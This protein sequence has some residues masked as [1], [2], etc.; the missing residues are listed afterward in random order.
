MCGI[1]GVMQHPEATQLTRRMLA[2]M[3]HRGPDG[4]GIVDF[5]NGSL[6]MCRLRIRGP[7]SFPLPIR[8]E[9]TSTWVSYSGEIYGTVGSKESAPNGGPAEVRFMF[10]SALN[11]SQADGMFA[12]ASVTDR[13]GSVQSVRLSRDAFGIKP[14]YYRRISNGY[15]F[16]SEIAPLA[17]IP[18]ESLDLRAGAVAEF[19]AFGRVLADQTLYRQIESVPPG[20]TVQLDEQGATTTLTTPVADVPATASDLRPALRDSVQKCLVSDRQVGLALSGG[21]DSSIIAYELN[22][23]NVEDITTVSVCIPGVTDGLDDLRS[24]GLPPGGAWTTW[25]HQVA[26]FAPVDLL[27]LIDVAVSCGQ[28]TRMTSFPLYLAL[29]E[30]AKK[31][32]VVVLLTGEGADELFAGYPSYLSWKN[33]RS[34]LSSLERLYEFALPGNRRGMVNA[35]TR[36]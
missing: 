32:G 28:P 36:S 9:Q 29:A 18:S 27:P 34:H 2:R 4:E 1:A 15:A 14:L 31:A 17:D 12:F 13:A 24:L 30:A 26:T 11:G 23:L 19:L 33:N 7:L 10:Q 22:S 20:T 5:L 21:L 6:G 35:L 16:G 8:N 3:D 25:R